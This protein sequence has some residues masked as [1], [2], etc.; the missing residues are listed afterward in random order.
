M[1]AITELQDTAPFQ[2]NNRERG[3]S[4]TPTQ[5][6]CP[7]TTFAASYQD[8]LAK[9]WQATLLKEKEKSG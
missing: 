3:T 1:A 6:V 4:V 7:Q 9:C 5:H 8:L 2:E